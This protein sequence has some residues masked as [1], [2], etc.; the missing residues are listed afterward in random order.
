MH[1]IITPLASTCAG[2]D[3]LQQEL[4]K[5]YGEVNVNKLCRR[6]ENKQVEVVCFQLAGTLCEF[7]ADFQ[8]LHSCSELFA[9]AW[10][11]AMSV[12]RSHPGLKLDDIYPMVWQPCL[13]HCIKL[14]TSLADLSIR[15]IDIDREFKY[16][17]QNLDTYL[18]ALFKGVTQCTGE[19]IDWGKIKTAIKRTKQYWEL[20]RYREGAN[21]FLEIRDSLGL[22]NGDFKLVEKL[23]KEVL[24]LQPKGDCY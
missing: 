22:R 14:L 6:A 18:Q 10:R 19:H 13:E 4:G 5:D 15:L 17:Q 7:V 21:T 8:V 11:N 23:S 3:S 24:Y 12:A 2:L 1:N 20:C 16:Y 9:T